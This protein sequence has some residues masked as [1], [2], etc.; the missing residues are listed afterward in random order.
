[1][2][3]LIIKRIKDLGCWDNYFERGDNN[4]KSFSSYE[5]YL[6]S[7]S[8]EE[9]LFTFKHVTVVVNNAHEFYGRAGLNY[10]TQN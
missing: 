3:D 10:G 8:N 9:L 6:K 2:R 1:M 4:A 7:L 5:D